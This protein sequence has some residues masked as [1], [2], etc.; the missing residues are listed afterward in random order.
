MVYAR[1]ITQARTYVRESV[2]KLESLK[3][4]NTA[5]P[6]IGYANA[7]Q[8]VLNHLEY[9]KYLIDD[10]STGVEDYPEG[11]GLTAAN[12]SEPLWKKKVEDACKLLSGEID[13]AERKVQST[14]QMVLQQHNILQSRRTTVLTILASIFVPASFVGTLFSMNSSNWGQ[15]PVNQ[16]TISNV[17]GTISGEPS[18][19][20]S[21]KDSVPAN[22]ALHLNATSII[23]AIDNSL[24]GEFPR[25]RLQ[26]SLF[27]F[28]YAFSPCSA[29]LP[30]KQVFLAS[31]KL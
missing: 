23:K 31:G 8:M 25:S 3:Y 26:S 29:T 15:D 10:L 17:N 4:E 14:R 30:E 13:I 21:T 9:Y 19:Q 7:G 20:N 22:I 16:S 11:W 18:G 6:T 2:K 5:H 24:N 27:F 28:L 1:G 12:W